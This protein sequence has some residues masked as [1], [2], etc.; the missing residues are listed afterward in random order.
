M[1]NLTQTQIGYPT[2]EIPKPNS[3][4][5]YYPYNN[6]IAPGYNYMNNKIQQNEQSQFLK[7]RPVSSKEEAIAS[8]IDLDGSLWVFPSVGNGKIYT[9]QIS[10]DGTAIFNTYTFVKEEQHNDTTEYVTKEEFNKVVQALMAAIQPKDNIGPAPAQS[11]TE[12][13][14]LNF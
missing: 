10:N 9:K 11:K 7:C 2:G 14:L 1:A 6:Y 8:Q 12:N 4:Q 5:F 13:T 3:Q